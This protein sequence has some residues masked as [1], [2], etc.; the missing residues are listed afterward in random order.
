MRKSV[1][2]LRR[3]SA[4]RTVTKSPWHGDPVGSRASGGKPFPSPPQYL[5][6][7]GGSRSTGGERRGIDEDVE[8][9]SHQQFD[10][11]SATL[12]DFRNQRCIG[13]NRE[14]CPTFALDRRRKLPTVARR[15]KVGCSCLHESS[16]RQA[17]NFLSKRVI[18]SA[19]PD[20]S[21]L[22]VRLFSKIFSR[23]SCPC[24]YQI[25]RVITR[26][27]RDATLLLRSV[28]GCIHGM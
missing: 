21:T 7:C 17:T 28:R 25:K 11:K 10:Q 6:E 20:A 16:S 19:V 24:R 23:L 14:G 2:F 15:E 26:G 18:Y 5:H 3:Y 13:A 4:R 1:R 8:S 27:L 9:C 12:G 22:R